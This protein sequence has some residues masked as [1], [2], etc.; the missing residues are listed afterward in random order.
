MTKNFINVSYNEFKV[1][2]L[3]SFC[4]IKKS[5]KK[6]KNI[7]N[8]LCAIM[9]EMISTII[10]C[11]FYDKLSFFS[12][13]IS[14]KSDK[15]YI[16]FYLFIKLNNKIKINRVKIVSKPR[17]ISYDWILLKNENKKTSSNLENYVKQQIINENNLNIII[18]A[19]QMEERGK[20]YRWLI[21][22]QS[23]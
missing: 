16:Y 10:C 19:I 9:K 13:C 14:T 18:K 20:K 12:I 6:Y 22:E 5:W 7:Y 1:D 11:S 23:K 8:H 15:F 4:K 17:C 2:I 3:N 21:F